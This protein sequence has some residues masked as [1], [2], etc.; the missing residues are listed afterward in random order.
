MLKTC[1][2]KNTFLNGYNMKDAVGGTTVAVWVFIIVRLKKM[3]LGLCMCADCLPS[4]P[5]ESI[6]VLTVYPL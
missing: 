2:H 3:I 5:Q 1:L 4:V 6:T